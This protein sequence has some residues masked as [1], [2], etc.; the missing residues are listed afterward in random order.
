MAGEETVSEKLLRQNAVTEA[1]DRSFV[2]IHCE[3]YANT[4]S[5]IDHAPDCPT[6]D[7]PDLVA[8]LRWLIEW[9]DT[10]TDKLTGH[11]YAPPDMAWATIEAVINEVE[12]TVRLT[13]GGWE[14][15]K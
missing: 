14:W 3:Y 9:R 7:V 2:C 15:V 8:L 6:M 10:F 11:L 5:E 4:P 1:L 12:K 13:D